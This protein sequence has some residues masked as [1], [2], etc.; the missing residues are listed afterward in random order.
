MVVSSEGVASKERAVS[1]PGSVERKTKGLRSK[2]GCLTCRI[3]RKV[4]VDLSVLCSILRLDSS[5]EMRPRKASR[6]MRIVSPIAHRVSW[7]F[8]KSSRV[9]KGMVFGYRPL[10]PLT[11]GAHRQHRASK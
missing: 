9:A 2:D 7:L 8:K 6:L 1:S 11:F 5:I 4:I 10:A 3:R